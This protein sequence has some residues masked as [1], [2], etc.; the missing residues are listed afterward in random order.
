MYLEGN[1]LDRP[2]IDVLRIELPT[3][4]RG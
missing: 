4:N 2:N 3:G 1:R